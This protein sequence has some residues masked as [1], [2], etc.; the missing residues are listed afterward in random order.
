MKKNMVWWFLIVIVVVGI[1]V[2]ITI[3]SKRVDYSNSKIAGEEQNNM[4]NAQQIE[5]VKIIILKE[6]N[7]DIAKSGD[8]VAM[9]YTGKLA[10][11]TIF[12]SNVDPKFNHVQPFVFTI[13]AGQVIRGWDVGIAGMKVGEGRIL[14]INPDYAYGEAGAG[15]VIPPNATI[16]FEVELLQIEK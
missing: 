7:G 16:S 3:N 13:G 4:Q 14:E 12:D 9:N 2:F 6:G 8:T 11:G 5:G 15:G 1:L 10:D